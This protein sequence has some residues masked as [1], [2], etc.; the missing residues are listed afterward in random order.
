[1]Q[2]KIGNILINEDD[3]FPVIVKASTQIGT[4]VKGYNVDMKNV[5]KP[6]VNEGLETKMKSD[7]VMGIYAVCVKQ[8]TSLV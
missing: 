8:N 1:M 6:T 3:F 5:W 7:N 2:L 4:Y